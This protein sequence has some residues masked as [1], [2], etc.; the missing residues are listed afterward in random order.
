MQQKKSISLLAGPVVFLLLTFIP[1]PGLELK[2][3]AAVAT[4][5]WMGIWWVSMPVDPAITAFLP[6]IVNAFF[7]LTDMGSLISSYAAELVF[8]LAGSN[9]IAIAWEVTGVDKRIAALVLGLVGTSVRQQLAVWF[10]SATVLSSVLPNTV[11][12]AIMCSIAISMLK[13]A[14]QGD[15]REKN[16]RV[17]PL[18]ML[19]IVWGA[20]NGGMLTPLGGSMNLITVS[21]I[22]ELTQ[23]EFM[24]T[25]WVVQLLPFG[26]VVTVVTLLFLLLLVGPHKTLP[27]SREYFRNMYQSMPKI[28]RAEIISLVAFVLAAGLAFTRQLY[29]SFL[30]DLKPGFVF[31]G[32]GLLMLFVRDENKKPILTWTYVEK[33]MM[34]G[35]FFL[36]A[37]GMA[38]GTLVNGSGAADEFA[39]LISRMDFSGEFF[40]IFIIVVFNVVLS[41]VINNTA[42]AAVTIPIIIG[43]AEGL[44][45]PVIPYVWIATV[46][47]NISFT[48][49]TSIRAIPIGL[50]LDPKFMFKRGLA[51][52]GVVIILVT[53]LGWV[54]IKFW[55]G[56]GVLS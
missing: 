8:L 2:V 42:C 6:V 26:I 29:Q 37:G 27:G 12:A 40:L 31:L 45:L 52:S 46:S 38:L 47:Y 39:N 7:S 43:I 20:N 22:E 55:P 1:I 11:V 41:D 50:G 9:A 48:L 23:R 28:N 15:L 54:C 21:Y 3:R 36:F 10:L 34:W 19:A 24:Y 25:D 35:L 5:A 13:F 53:I 18:I 4:V 51:I 56:F 33:N 17:G 32:F 30:P 14:G 44:S 49:P 16:N